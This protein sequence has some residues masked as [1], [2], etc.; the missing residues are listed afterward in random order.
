MKKLNNLFCLLLLVMILSMIPMF[1]VAET[2][3]ATETTS[4]TE[5]SPDE[6]KPE[7]PKYDVT[8]KVVVG[9]KTL[10]T[11]KVTVKDKDVKLQDDMYIIHKDSYYKFSS[12]KHLGE[13]S[14]S[15]TIPKYDGSPAW[16]TKWDN[17]ISVI[18]TAHTHKYKPGYNRIYH[19]SICE[20]GKTTNEVRHVDPAKD[21]DKIC[22][23][24]YKFNDNAELT[25]LW[26]SNIQL[27]PR[28]T[29]EVTEYIGYVHTY[30]DVT[31][32]TISARP[33][34]AMAKVTL[35][36]NLEIH[37]GNNKLEILVTA[38]DTV[39][40]K[41]YTVIAVKPARIENCL[42][43]SDCT[44]VSATLKPTVK[45]KVAATA[46][47]DAVFEKIMEYVAA[48][49]CKGIAI[50]PDFSKWSVNQVEVSFTGAQMKAICEKTEADLILE[51]PYKSVLTIPH[52]ELTVMTEGCDSLVLYVRKDNTFEIVCDGRTMRTPPVITFT[53]TK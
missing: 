23:C 41:V 49:N 33:F 18:Y 46:V 19:W 27:S 52:S 53:T 3:S 4:T 39:A 29:K 31:S 21:E 34:D 44:T 35:P 30:R 47:S 8:V 15:I 51:T 12:Y 2:T 13:K 50:C 10:Y 7:P 24:G 1:A 17:T 5:T 32:T 37:E 38:E 9:N 25:T 36:E 42:V 16:K 6:T 20:C 45:Q 48:D 40:T 26:L 43:L 22:T 14:D 28:F 11:Y